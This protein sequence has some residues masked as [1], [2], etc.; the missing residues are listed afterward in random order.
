MW[1]APH[2][3][4]Q[5]VCVRIG[6]R[7]GGIPSVVQRGGTECAIDQ[8]RNTQRWV[9]LGFEYLREEALQ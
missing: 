3:H 4:A 5:S 6:C 7:C 9:L 8:W 1:D 2:Y